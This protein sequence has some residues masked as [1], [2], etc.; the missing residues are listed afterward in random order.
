[1]SKVA[2]I[3]L[4]KMGSAMAARLLTAGH[5]LNIY[6][7]TASRG[8]SL[9]RLGANLCATPRAAC[10]GVD[11]VISMVADDPASRSVWLDSDGILASD[12]ADGAFAIECSTLSHDWVTQLA[13]QAKARGLRYIDAP[14]TGLPQSAAAGGLTLLIGADAG[15]L[16]AARELLA[17]FSN[18]IIHF[19][20]V[21]TGTAYKLMINML[22]AVQIASAAECMAIA[23]RVGL[24][25]H[26]VADAI[27]TGQAASPQVIRNTQRM[28]NGNHS[29]DI[30]FTPQ[31]RLKDVRYGLQLAQKFKIGVPFAALA[32]LEFAALCELASEQSNESKIF[33]VARSKTHEQP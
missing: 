26:V 20:A 27:A 29:R 22:G 30:V 1:M 11:A 18:R 14:V 21:G 33:E 24:D 16:S 12:L 3:G 32:G 23:E 9:V 10:I 17:A 13:P 4:G 8:T 25:L 7:R 19:G 6:N 2:F 31:L 15:D 5:E 28:A